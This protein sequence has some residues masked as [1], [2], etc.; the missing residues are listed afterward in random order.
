MRDESFC[1]ICSSVYVVEC[2]VAA[3]HPPLAP[4]MTQGAR[5]RGF[6]RQAPF[7]RSQLICIKSSCVKVAFLALSC[8][9]VELSAIPSGPSE[10]M[11]AKDAPPKE[12]PRHLLVFCSRCRVPKMT[13]SVQRQIR[14]QNF[15][16]VVL[17]EPLVN[18]V[19]RYALFFDR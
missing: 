3:I 16:K 19:I 4:T 8:D 6:G 12:V 13:T 10:L 18:I 2:A 14:R 17:Q 9:G 1:A 15:I 11:N 7:N 5:G